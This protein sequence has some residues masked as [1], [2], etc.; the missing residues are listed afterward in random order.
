[1]AQIPDRKDGSQD[2][3]DHRRHRGSHHA[4]VKS[5]DENRVQNDVDHRARQRGYHGESRTSVRPD[6]RI[7]GLPEH[8]K[9]DSKRNIEEVFLRI[10]EGFFIYP[11]AEQGQ[12][13][14]PEYQINDR[15]H[16]A[17]SNA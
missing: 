3:A 11:A 1:M 4:P 7:H 17:C 6:D 13:P 14:I 16:N 5:E 2:L 15:Q 12:Y 8:I 9:R 10:P